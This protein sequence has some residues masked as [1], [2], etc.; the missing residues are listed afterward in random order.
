MNISMAGRGIDLTDA[1]KA[2]I[3]GAVETF[4]KY[5]LNIISV[6]VIVSSSSDK[7]FNVEFVISLPNKNTIVINQKDKDAYNAI[8]LVIDR[9]QKAL[10]R[11]HD[12]IKDHKIENPN[13]TI[14]VTN[15]ES[16]V[17]EIIPVELEIYKP[18]EIEEALEILKSK[19]EQFFVFN[20]KDDN[21]RVLFKRGDGKFGLY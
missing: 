4:S 8:D 15:V 6:N 17:E 13:K 5:N 1:M 19:D 14:E 11:H 10:R 2:Q 3:T 16:E 12:K 21:L 18:L 20:D 9:A 7:K